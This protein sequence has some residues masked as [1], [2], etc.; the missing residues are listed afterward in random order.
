[1]S[2]T[3]PIPFPSE[4]EAL[5]NHL[6]TE[7]HL[8]PAQRLLAVVDALAAAEALSQAG[9]VRAAQ[10][11]YQQALED[12]WRSRMMEFIKQHIVPK[13]ETERE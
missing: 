1:M 9:Q 7:R 2:F 13:D 10:L 6:R 12:D 4:C 11:E 3:L 5:R 8:T